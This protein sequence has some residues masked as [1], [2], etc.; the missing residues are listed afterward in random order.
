MISAFENS[1]G[2]VH[3]DENI[4]RIWGNYPAMNGSFQ[5]QTGAVFQRFGISCST[6]GCG[7]CDLRECF[8]NEFIRHYLDYPKGD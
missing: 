5:G 3:A 7:R 2:L 4:G 8:F 6:N 1:L